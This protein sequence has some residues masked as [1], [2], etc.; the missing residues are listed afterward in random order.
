L[1]NYIAEDYNKIRQLIDD[2][3]LIRDGIQDIT[4]DLKKK[5][6]Q[7]D[8]EENLEQLKD[9]IQEGKDL[10]NILDDDEG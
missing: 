8:G 4:G 9:F 7:K 10:C 5:G 3:K 6:T 2:Q 1:K